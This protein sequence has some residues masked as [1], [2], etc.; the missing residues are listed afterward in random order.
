MI[1]D[2]LLPKKRR[3]KNGRFFQR[4]G[5]H[6]LESVVFRRFSSRYHAPLKMGGMYMKKVLT[7][8]VLVL[9]LVGVSVASATEYH[10]TIETKGN[11]VFVD[12]PLF[13]G[14]C[15]ESKPSIFSERFNGVGIRSG[16]LRSGLLKSGKVVLVHS[17]YDKTLNFITANGE[18]DVKVSIASEDPNGVEH[19]VFQVSRHE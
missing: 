1:F 19:V 16:C 12:S 5:R 4:R 18:K 9:S 15:T 2:S 3:N 7:A 11:S 13:V 17:R 8:G 14:Y 6:N 10:G